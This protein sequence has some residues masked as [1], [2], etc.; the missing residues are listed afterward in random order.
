[1]IVIIVLAHEATVVHHHRSAQTEVQSRVVAQRALVIPIHVSQNHHVV[2]HVAR[3]LAR[4]QT[5]HAQSHAA[6]AVTLAMV[7][8]KHTIIFLQIT[9]AFSTNVFSIPLFTL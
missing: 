2:I 1:M 9:H 3:A 7:T 4:S 5:V 6:K 8:I